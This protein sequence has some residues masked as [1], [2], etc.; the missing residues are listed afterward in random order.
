MGLSRPV[1]PT[2]THF[3]IAKKVTSAVTCI[4]IPWEKDENWGKRK[5]DTSYVFFHP[6]QMYSSP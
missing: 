1:F 3:S 2:L 6:F 4:L 5:N